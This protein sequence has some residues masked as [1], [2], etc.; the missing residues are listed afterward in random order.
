MTLASFDAVLFDMDGTL[1]DTESAYLEEWV[2]AANL[3]G[4][5]I[6]Q[7]LWHQMLGRP[8][9]DCHQLVQDA[10]GASFKLDLFAAEYRARL[11]DRLQDH[12]P[13][14]P[15]VLNLLQDLK[16]QGTPLAVA[17]SAT[18]KSAETYL[19]T[20]GIRD[21]F[22]HVI[23]RDDVDQ[24]KPHPEPF[25]KAAAALSVTPER[26]IAMED[27]EA[28]IR[29]AHGAGAIPIMIPSLKQPANE[30]AEL[31][32]LICNDMSEVHAHLRPTL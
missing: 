24:G 26:C 13:V 28:G 32:H 31:C 20:A 27:T 2:R 3:Q 25:Q 1:I 21:F 9:I 18:R 15:G 16:V 19:S 22:S 4:F 17:T 12:V 11:N 14:M 23:T 29:S 10:F 30:I 6:T 5:E 8:T 7:D